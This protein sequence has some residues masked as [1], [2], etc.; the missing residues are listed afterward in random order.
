MGEYLTKDE[1][2]N[3]RNSYLDLEVPELG[4]KVRIKALSVAERIHFEILLGKVKEEEN[5]M[6]MIENVVIPL[7]SKALVDETGAL[8]FT[9]DDKGALRQ[10]S[11][12]PLLRIYAATLRYSRMAAKDFQDALANFDDGQ[13]IPSV[14]S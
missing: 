10:L 12:K 8:L 2:L 9:E 1:I 6:S 7:V 3:A 11:E 13:S 14:T 4:G 5:D